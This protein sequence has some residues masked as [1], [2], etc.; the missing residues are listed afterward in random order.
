MDFVQLASNALVVTE[1][2]LDLDPPEGMAFI[3]GGTFQ[4]GDT[5]GEGGSD[6]AVCLSGVGWGWL[7]V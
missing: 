4:L 7:F 3:P 1:T 5:F 2:I 6:R